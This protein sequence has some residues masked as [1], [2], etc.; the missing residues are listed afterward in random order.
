MVKETG[1]TGVTPEQWDPRA[2]SDREAFVD[3]VESDLPKLYHFAAR[4][5]RYRESVADLEPAELTAEDVVSEAT[6]TALQ[7]LRRGPH[8]FAFRAWL[9]HLIKASIERAVRSSRE[10]HSREQVRLEREIAPALEQELFY[11]Y[12]P[13]N[14]LTWEDVIPDEDSPA[15]DSDLAISENWAGL[16]K[17]LNSLPA[18]ERDVFVLHAIEGLPLEQVA[19]MRRQ[20]LEEVRRLYQVAREALRAQLADRMNLGGE[21]APNAE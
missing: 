19:A 3:L 6:V 17:T 14:S 5:I 8:R 9:R 12:Q 11:F 4:E 1:T 15:P 2:A 21:P 10:R 18:Q 7:L 13:D 20:K 16:E